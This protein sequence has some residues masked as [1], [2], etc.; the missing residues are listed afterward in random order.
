MGEPAK[1]AR[2][3]PT[4]KGVR[5]GG[6]AKGVPNKATANARAAIAAFIDGNSGRLQEWLDQIAET[7]GPKAA[8]NCFVDL[9]EY[10]VPKLARHEVAGDPERPVLAVG[11]N[12]Q[13]FQELAAKAAREV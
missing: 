13:E 7:E 10:H 11:M 4:P 9:I 12:A 3:S 8:F 1:V 5:L 2:S 6:R